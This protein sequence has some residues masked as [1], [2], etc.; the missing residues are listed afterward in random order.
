MTALK[1]MLAFAAASGAVSIAAASAQEATG[2]PPAPVALEADAPAPVDAPAAAAEPA[3]NEDE[4]A[5]LLNARQQVKQGVTLT[6]TVD[7]KVIDTRKDTIVYAKDDPIRGSEAGPSALEKLQ[8][9]FDSQTLTRREALQEA[10]TDFVLADLDRSETLTADEFVFLVMGWQN[11]D[12]T[13]VG[14]DRFI[15]PYFHVD[16]ATADAE[17]QAQA[18]AKFAAM[19]GAEVAISKKALSRE[20]TREFDEHDLDDDELLTGDE[21][22]NFRASVRG[23]PI[24]TPAN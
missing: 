16:Q 21:L 11:A 17:H 23:E 5:D 15:D 9:E 20:V 10:K 8:A 3:I 6:K 13:G 2:L 12:I 7:G 22:L 4:M 14:R 19:A 1:M 24:V 18:R